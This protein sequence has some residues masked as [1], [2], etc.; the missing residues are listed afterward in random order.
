MGRLGV[1]WQTA[2]CAYRPN[3]LELVMGLSKVCDDTR[4]NSRLNF[5]F[6]GSSETKTTFTNLKEK[7]GVRG[8]QHP[9]RVALQGRWAAS[10]VR[11]TARC[12]PLFLPFA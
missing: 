1:R 12:L 10:P 8:V 5:H 3:S 11:R 9:E 7:S 2:A 4:R 6:S